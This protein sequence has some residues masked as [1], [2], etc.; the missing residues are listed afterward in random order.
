MSDANAEHALGTF[1]SALIQDFGFNDGRPTLSEEKLAHWTAR[2]IGDVPACEETSRD[3]LAFAARLARE[4]PE[5]MGEAV[6]Q[7]IG[8]AGLVLVDVEAALQAARSAGLTVS[9][10]ALERA[11]GIASSKIPVGAAGKQPGASSPLETLFKT[12]KK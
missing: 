12:P 6:G 10:A 2:C 9:A 4:Y 1:A 3:L 7:L 11:T 5:A 8:L